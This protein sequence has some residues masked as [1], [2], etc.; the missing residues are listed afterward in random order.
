M[1]KEMRGDYRLHHD[2]IEKMSE[3]FVLESSFNRVSELDGLT[4]FAAPLVGITSAD[5]PLFTVLKQNDV[6]GPNHMSPKEWLSEAQSVIS[7]FLPFSQ[8]VRIANRPFG[9]AAKEWLYG[10]IEGE[11]VNNA[12]RKYLVEH[13]ES[14]GYTAVAP[15]LDRRFRVIERRSNWSERHAAYIAGLGTFSLSRS[16]ITER[17][18]AG[19]I[20]SVIVSMPLKPTERPYTKMDEYCSMCGACILR[21]PPLAISETGKDNAVCSAYLDRVLSRFQPRYGCGKCQTGVPCE[22]QR[23]RAAKFSS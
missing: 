3:R 19:R 16:L 17:G 18:S 21:C 7:Y 6:V 8:E 11:L 14:F 22:Y 1:T 15:A 12:L 20:G 23:P 2:D 4:I 9:H 5:D 10:R 13:F